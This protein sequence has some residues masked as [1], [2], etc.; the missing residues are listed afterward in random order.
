MRSKKIINR[1]LKLRTA[2]EMNTRYVH[3]LVDM[4]N[5]RPFYKVLAHLATWLLL[6]GFVLAPGTFAPP[7]NEDEEDSFGS[8]LTKHMSLLVISWIIT[9]IGALSMTGLWFRWRKNYLWIHDALF[10]PGMLHSLAGVVSSISTTTFDGILPADNEV[11]N[12]SLQYLGASTNGTDFSTTLDDR[13]AF[14]TYSKLIVTATS[15]AVCGSLFVFYH[16]V[17]IRRMRKEHN[18]VVDAMNAKV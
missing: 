12:D 8:E 9:G 14:A 16:F 5:I 1:P 3:M 13:N 15:A 7:A 2:P 11:V 17:M 6:A 10:I 18:R 4:E